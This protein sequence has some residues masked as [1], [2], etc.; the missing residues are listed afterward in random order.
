MKKLSS[1]T[2]NVILVYQYSRNVV[3]KASS[4][5]ISLI[6]SLTRLT[7][8]Q[9]KDS[10]LPIGKPTEEVEPLDSWQWQKTPAKEAL[11]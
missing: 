4:S 7:E 6:A 2:A 11:L 9:S 1:K 3:D 5:V 10:V 8:F